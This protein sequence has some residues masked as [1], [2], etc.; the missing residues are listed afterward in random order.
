MRDIFIPI[1]VLAL[2]MYL[3]SAVYYTAGIVLDTK[4]SADGL[5]VNKFGH[6]ALLLLLAGIVVQVFATGAWCV[7]T[8]LSPFA[9]H[10]GTLSVLAWLMAIAIAVF[11][12]RFKQPAIGAAALPVVCIVLLGGLLLASRRPDD[13]QVLQSEIVS[14]HVFSILASYAFFVVAFGCACCYLIQNSLLK[15]HSTSPLQK[16]M[17]PLVTLD[18][19][20]FHSVAFALPCLT[21]G[22]A[23][24]VVVMVR[25][26]P[27]M[28]PMRWLL[29][30][31]NLVAFCTWLLYVSYVAARFLAG[32]RGVKL[33]YILVAGLVLALGLYCVPN[34][35]H[36]F[37]PQLTSGSSRAIR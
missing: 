1:N 12:F 20:A 2:V 26:D 17:P 6:Y 3:A 16:K 18:R 23:I 13:A 22:L 14:I 36:H 28:T 11:H 8:H 15:S 24:G 19:V 34:F 29:D 37:S 5:P 33:Q 10:Y 25:I 27:T 35:T 7:E 9:G 30:P 32:W 4:R 31:H 21:V